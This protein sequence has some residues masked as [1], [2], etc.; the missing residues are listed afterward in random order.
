MEILSQSELINATQRTKAL[1]IISALFIAFGALYSP[2]LLGTGVALI[3]LLA[4]L[5][6]YT[7]L[8]LYAVSRCRATVP[9]VFAV[10]GDVVEVP[11]V[12]ENPT[13]V[14]IATAEISVAYSQYL[15]L[16][17]G[18]KASLVLIPARGSVKLMLRFKAR[19][20]NHAVGPL[21][22]AVRDVFGFFR[23]N[24]TLEVIRTIKCVPRASETVV[25][26]LMVFTRTTGLTRSKRAGYGVELYSV[27]EYKIGDDVRRIIWKYLASKHKLVVKE[28]ELEAMNRVI[29]VVDGTS[30]TWAGPYGYTP[31]E[32]SCRVV[33]SISKYL[34]KRGDLMGVII[35]AENGIYRTPKLTR[36]Y[37][38]VI[39]PFAEYRPCVNEIKDGNNRVI[40]L[41][42]AFKHIVSMLPRERSLIFFLAPNPSHQYKQ[43]LSTI[44]K[45]LVA[46]GHEIYIVLPLITTFEIKGMPVWA[47]SIYRVKTFNIVKE[48]IEYAKILRKLGIKTIVAGAQQ[49][50]QMIVSLLEAKYRY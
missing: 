3:I 36:S 9:N 31:F 22:L 15:K 10:E 40:A 1:I 23:F 5:R 44:A 6:L 42:N 48:H 7:S 19:V 33:A 50:P 26:R 41:E 34:S 45:K 4:S 8:E 24:Y 32:Y 46:L 49:V 18:V 39:E 2:H 13:P 47:Q 14:P 12:I 27:R 17:E 20:G 38:R 30:D 11:I 25:K 43:I 37:R 35:F 16:V 29:F 28:M 21:K